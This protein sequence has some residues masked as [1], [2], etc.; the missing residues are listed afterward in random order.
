[1]ADQNVTVLH[2]T[3]VVDVDTGDLLDSAYVRVE[4][5][6]ITEI[7]SD[8]TT[9][10][11]ADTVIELTDTTLVP[12]LMDMEVDL[13]LGGP[14]AGLSDPVTVD[15]VEMTLRAAANARRTLMAGFTTVRNLGLF[16]K[17]GGYLLD[18]ALAKAIELGWVDGCRVIPAGHAICPVG[19]S[20]RVRRAGSR[21]TSCRSR[22]RRASPTASIRS[23]TPCATRSSTAPS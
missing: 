20:I 19:T 5:D 15:P 8:A 22:S 23:D 21:H 1:M 11:D 10:N 13:V 18:V 12:G 17:T 9:S 14:G 4:G 16:V 7:A 6:R 3:H 2:A